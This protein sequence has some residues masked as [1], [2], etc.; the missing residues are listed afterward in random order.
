MDREQLDRWCE[1]GILALVLAVLVFG[2]LAFGA[3]RTRE[4][5]VI[6]LLTVGVLLLWATRLWLNPKPKLLWPPV[7]WA[8]VVF[9]L[10]AIGR[11]FTADIEYVARKE[12][13]RILVYAFL[14]L[15][16]VNNLPR[17]ETTQI[18]SFTLIFLAMAIASYAIYQ[19]L[20]DSDKVWQ[21]VKPYRHRGSGT[22]VC[23][24]HLGGFLEMLLPVGLA[25]TL[26][27]RLKPLMKIFL[28]YAS[29]VIL[30]GIAVTVSRGTW[31]ACGVALLLF[32]GL[33]VLRGPRRLPALLLLGLIVAAGFV[34][35]QK[36]G[37]ARSRVTELVSPQGKINDDMRLVL[38]GPAIE[39]WEQNMW[40][41]AGPDHFDYRF[42]AVRPEQIQLQPERT[43]NDY[44]NTLADWGIVG[45]VLVASAWGLLAVGILKTWPVVRRA[46]GGTSGTGNSNRFAF[47]LGASFGL[48][49]ILLH[50]FVDFNMHMPANAIL[51]I[52]LMALLTT[53]LRFVSD[54]YWASPRPWAKVLA[55]VVLL[56][57]MVCLGE[58]ARRQAHELAWLE[59]AAGA[60]DFSPEM[61]RLLGRAFAIEPKNGDTAYAIGEAY[62]IQSSE[63]GPNYQDLAATAI[64]WFGCSTNLNPWNGYSYLR[65]GMCLDWLDRKA[66]SGPYFDRAA[67]LDPNGYFMM[68]NI[69][70]HYVESGKYAA[71]KPWFERSLRLR[72]ADNPIAQN[73]LQICNL[74]L[75]E[76]ATNA[77][78]ARL[79]EL[80]R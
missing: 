14:F 54:R 75:L 7:C 77:I 30:A 11:Y 63:G 6:E 58:Q 33:L 52:T 51:A 22:Y 56:A 9:T 41:G 74:R 70:V 71:A 16:L 18:I 23:P 43:H 40:W 28:G 2:P 67:Q 60:P 79:D 32:L 76:A 27:G 15:A 59:R 53:H 5:L 12:L 8:V 48:L 64:Q 69:G 20:A 21:Y 73:Y 4:F 35:V 25:Y 46:A 31:I 13:L 38:W 45:L 49:A 80:P 26:V 19:F 10:Y 24:D 72:G 3:V 62:R 1:R 66:E 68:A 55:S 42:R 50:S 34:F 17:Q 36:S 57:G 47:V 61:V 65:Y 78:R 29:F 37:F 39:L 44:V